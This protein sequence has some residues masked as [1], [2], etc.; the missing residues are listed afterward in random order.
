MSAPEPQVPAGFSVEFDGGEPSGTARRLVVSGELDLMTS[1]RF[2]AA[3]EELL[4]DPGTGPVV[5]DLTGVAFFDS[6]ALG[7]LLQAADRA[8]N[9]NRPLRV[10]PSERVRKVMVLAGTARHFGIEE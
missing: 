1:P 10:E 7:V 8:R 3:L 5:A 6:S 9:R 2:A 4:D